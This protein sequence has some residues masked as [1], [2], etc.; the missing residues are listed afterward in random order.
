M[1]RSAQTKPTSPLVEQT[2]AKARILEKEDHPT[3]SE[4]AMIEAEVD[5]KRIDNLVAL[6]A[7]MILLVAIVLN[8]TLEFLKVAQVVKGL[9]HNQRYEEARARQ[10]G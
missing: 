5:S 2:E 8:L 10:A 6:V 3:E 7:L 1:N 9:A 4:V